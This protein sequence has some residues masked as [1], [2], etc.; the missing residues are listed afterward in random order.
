MVVSSP[1][2]QTS[3]NQSNLATDEVDSNGEDSK[4]ELIDR[5]NASK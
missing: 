5:S 2:L 1:E 4:D 3:T